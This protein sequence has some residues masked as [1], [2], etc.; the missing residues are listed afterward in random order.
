MAADAKIRVVLVDIM[1]KAVRTEHHNVEK[2]ENTIMTE[3][4]DLAPGVYYMKI[5]KDGFEEPSFIEKFMKQ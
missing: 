5:I 1:G 4:N 3:I 2:G